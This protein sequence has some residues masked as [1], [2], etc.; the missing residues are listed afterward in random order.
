MDGWVGKDPIY[1]IF[2]YGISGVGMSRFVRYAM[3]N[4]ATVTFF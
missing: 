2:K 1:K 4:F 3:L